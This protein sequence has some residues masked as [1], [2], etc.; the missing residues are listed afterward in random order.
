MFSWREPPGGICGFAFVHMVPGGLSPLPTEL[1]CSENPREPSGSFRRVQ[2]REGEWEEEAGRRAWGKDRHSVLRGE[3]TY[4]SAL[5]CPLT[6]F[7]F[8]RAAKVPLCLL[9]AQG[10]KLRHLK[11]QASNPNE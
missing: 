6:V 2:G 3:I 5:P 8:S 10:L 4:S 7:R 1:A 11:G 9:M